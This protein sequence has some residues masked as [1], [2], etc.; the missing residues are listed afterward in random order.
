MAPPWSGEGRR[1]GERFICPKGHAWELILQGC[2]GTGVRHLV[3]PVCGSA[4]L[5][6]TCDAV[7]VISQQAETLFTPP[8]SGDVPPEPGPLRPE[9][10]GYE[11]LGELGR[12]GMGV[13]YRARQA[14]LNRI[15]ALKMIL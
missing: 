5:E 10:T 4:A 11:I 7:K 12:G 8:P 15:V 13:V 3:C 6:P 1:M 14:G 9:V 2:C